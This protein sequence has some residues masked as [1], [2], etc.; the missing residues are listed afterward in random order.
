MWAAKILIQGRWKILAFKCTI[1]LK[2]IVMLPLIFKGASTARVV[3]FQMIS[4]AGGATVPQGTITSHKPPS[5][6]LYP[7]SDWLSPCWQP[8]SEMHLLS[9]FQACWWGP[10]G[11]PCWLCA[12][13]TPWT[14]P[15]RSSTF[16]RQ[17]G[18]EDGDDP[19]TGTGGSCFLLLGPLWWLVL[20]GWGV[21]TREGV[22]RE[23]KEEK[24][25]VL[26][27]CL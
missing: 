7:A 10:W 15:M 19:V 21:V 3:V 2:L 25:Y 16:C 22:G 12:R 20:V 11:R 14:L 1:T 5:P 4:E 8:V 26:L 6:C 27:P 17:G 23:Q 18:R 24:A 9:F 13:A